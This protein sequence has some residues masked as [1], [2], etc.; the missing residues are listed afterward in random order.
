LDK[1]LRLA[2]KVLSK[3]MDST[4]LTPEKLEIGVLQKVND[5]IVFRQLEAAE[6]DILLKEAEA[7]KKTE[8]DDS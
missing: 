4:S 6:V 2:V 5:E 8:K 1:A 7:E 3:T